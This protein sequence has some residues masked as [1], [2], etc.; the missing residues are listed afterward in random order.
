MK[1][2]KRK[3][4]KMRGRKRRSSNSGV[5][6]RTARI[7]SSCSSVPSLYQAYCAPAVVEAFSISCYSLHFS[8]GANNSITLRVP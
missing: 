4:R 6:L 5:S 3:E 1:M 2:V 7:L 8:Q